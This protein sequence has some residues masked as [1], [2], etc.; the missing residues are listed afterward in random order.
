MEYRA[1][2]ATGTSYEQV[3]AQQFPDLPDIIARTPDMFHAN[4]MMPHEDV[5][6]YFRRCASDGTLGLLD[7]DATPLSKPLTPLP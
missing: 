3:F 1:Q 6:Q 2:A 5:L 7:L 4:T